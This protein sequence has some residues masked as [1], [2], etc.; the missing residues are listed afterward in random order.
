MT[1]CPRLT[2]N[3][4][5]DIAVR[6]APHGWITFMAISPDDVGALFWLAERIP[7]A[8]Y[9]AASVS[10]P[11]AEADFLYQ[12]ALIADFIIG[13]DDGTSTALPTGT[14]NALVEAIR[15]ASANGR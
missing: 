6:N 1:Q 4:D 13:F 7:E 8:R 3:N 15:R 9:S 14:A 12:S 2:P 5:V 11:A 10:V